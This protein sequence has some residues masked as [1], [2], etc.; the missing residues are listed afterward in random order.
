[1]PMFKSFAEF[2]SAT[3]A[4]AAVSTCGDGLRCN[5][6]LYLALPVVGH[7][8]GHHVAHLLEI[9][10]HGGVEGHGATRRAG[11]AARGAATVGPPPPPP[12]PDEPPPPIRYGCLLFANVLGVGAVA[13]T[14]CG[15]VDDVPAP[16]RCICDMLGYSRP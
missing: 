11:R 5:L 6:R 15:A 16:E 2:A 7:R 13:K 14:S 10:V 3:L 8:P 4:R 9:G 1:M 12:P